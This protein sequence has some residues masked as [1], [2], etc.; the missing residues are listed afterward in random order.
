MPSG[1]YSFI[2]SLDYLK[3]DGPLGA[4]CKIAADLKI[5]TSKTVATRLLTSP[6]RSNIGTMESNDILSGKPFLFADADYPLE[7]ESPKAQM[8]L[9]D[10]QMQIALTFFNVLWLIKDNSVDFSRGF[11]QHPQGSRFPRISANNWTTRYSKADG[12]LLETKFSKSELRNAISTYNSLFGPRPSDDVSESLSPGNAGKADRMSYALFFLQGA[13]AMRDP[14]LKVTNY[15]IGFESL[16]STSNTGLAHQVAERIAILIG[17]DSR[18]ALE[19]YKNVK[20]AYSTR[21]KVVHGGGQLKSKM[22]EYLRQSLTCD[23]YLR[24]LL[25]AAITNK[26]VAEALAAEK[27]EALDQFFLESLFRMAR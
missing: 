12:Q 6:L 21:S 3:L 26:E 5:S 20:G 9:L 17:K 24:R 15:C 16:V 13:R 7:D 25:L 22:D 23:D 2:A 4:D 8:S 14:A 11:L 19:I 1:K 27:T 18:D 10:T